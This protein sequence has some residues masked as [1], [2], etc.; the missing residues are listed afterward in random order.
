MGWITK[1]SSAEVPD[2]KSKSVRARSLPTSRPFSVAAFFAALLFLSLIGTL[3]GLTLLIITPSPVGLKVVL[4]GVVV[5][6]FLWITGFLKR[7]NALCPLCKGTPLL[8]SGAR[9]HSKARRFYPLN[10]GMTATL[11]IIATQRFCC[12]YCGSDFDLLK[13]PSHRREAE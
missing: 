9:P 10:H 3:T 6:I 8:N 7:R 5:S 2:A 1:D 11:S 12:M 4:A 13:T